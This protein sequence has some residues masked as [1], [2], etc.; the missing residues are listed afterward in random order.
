[1]NMAHQQSFNLC[2][3]K[4]PVPNLNKEEKINSD[5][6]V[7]KIEW[8]RDWGRTWWRIYNGDKATMMANPWRRWIQDKDEVVMAMDMRQ[9]KSWW[10]RSCNRGRAT[11]SLKP[12]WWRICVNH[13]ICDHV[14]HLDIITSA[15]RDQSCHSLSTKLWTS[16]R[17]SLSLSTFPET[18][19]WDP[20][21]IYVVEWHHLSNYK[22]ILII[23]LIG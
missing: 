22:S 21:G 6:G 20:S 11:T 1:M 8:V 3:E 9:T 4:N 12:W 2:P 19:N 10:R 7:K 23:C 5:L 16:Q 14:P 17:V 13:Q 15:L 18:R